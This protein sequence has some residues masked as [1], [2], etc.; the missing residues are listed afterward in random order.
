VATKRGEVDAL[1]ALLGKLEDADPAKK[2]VQ[3]KM[4]AAKSDLAVAEGRL[5]GISGAH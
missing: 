5:A 1:T 3:A 4:A 2:D